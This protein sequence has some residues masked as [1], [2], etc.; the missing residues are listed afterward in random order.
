[1]SGRGRWAARGG[2]TAKG[3]G[4]SRGGAGTARGG[5][6]GGAGTARGGSRG[7]SRGKFKNKKSISYY[8]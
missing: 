7:G 2:G 5:T 3:A 1:M 6:R 8:F 4:I